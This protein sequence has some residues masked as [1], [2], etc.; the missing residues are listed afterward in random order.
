[1]QDPKSNLSNLNP[2]FQIYTIEK[3]RTNSSDHLFR[4]N[5]ADFFID[6]RPACCETEEG[7]ER[8]RDSHKIVKVHCPERI[9]CGNSPYLLARQVKGAITRGPPPAT[10]TPFQQPKTSTADLYFLSLF[11][12]YFRGHKCLN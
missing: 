4:A 3:E 11:Y 7:G 9:A 5:S 12:L 6:P 1:L 2:K 8:E 10:L